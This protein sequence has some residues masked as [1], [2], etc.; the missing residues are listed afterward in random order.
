MVITARQKHQLS[1]LSLRLLLNGQNI[2]N[3]TEHRL[4][5]LNVGRKCLWQTQIEYICQSMQ[6][7]QQQQQQ[8]KNKRVSCLST[9]AYRQFQYQ[10]NRQRSH[11]NSHRLCVCSV[12]WLW[13]ST[14]TKLNSRHRRAGRLI[15]P[16]PSLSTEQKM[17]ALGILNLPQQLTYNKGTF[18]Y[19]VFNNNSR[20]YLAQLFIS[21]LSH[22]TNSRN[23]LYVPRPKLDLFKTSISF[24]GGSLWNSLRQNIKFCMSLSCFKLNLCQYMS[25]NNLSSNW[26]GF[27][28]Q[29]FRWSLCILKNLGFFL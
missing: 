5:G 4:L 29:S 17:S 6:K 15:C 27:I 7:Q 12:G 16:D 11:K 23:N 28:C 1:G 9:A 10:K 8:N 14:I 19:K 24:A 25:E 2:E 22:Y 18:M 3:V 21:H 20:N 26:D 13:R